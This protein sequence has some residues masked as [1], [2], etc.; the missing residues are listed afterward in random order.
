MLT[1]ALENFIEGYTKE[2]LYTSIPARVLSVSGYGD[3]QTVTVSPSISRT[4]MTGQVIGNDDIII[5]DVPVINPSGG[6]GLLSFPI[7]VG[8]NVWLNFSMRSLE[9]RVLS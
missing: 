1:E 3:S 4:K 2:N 5:Y 7:I 6:G 8:D 9:E